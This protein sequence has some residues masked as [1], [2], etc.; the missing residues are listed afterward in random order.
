MRFAFTLPF[1]IASH[2]SVFGTAQAQTLGNDTLYRPGLT[3][4]IRGGLH[5]PA[6]NSPMFDVM[7][8]LLTLEKADFRNPSLGVEFG[9]WVGDRAEIVAGVDAGHMAVSSEFRSRVGTSEPVRQITH[10]SAGPDIF[11]G[12][13]V[14]L[15]PKGKLDPQSGWQQKRWN[16]F[17][18]GGGGQAHYVLQQSG[19][20]VD[21]D[22]DTIVFPATYRSRGGSPYG[23][24]AAGVDVTVFGK[25]GIVVEGRQQWGKAPHTQAGFH[26]NLGKF[27]VSGTRVTAGI[28]VHF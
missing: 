8:E 11:I 21:A 25:V 2:L 7:T 26:D 4:T 27:D 3:I 6:G 23:Y 22:D 10:Y 17:A 18:G 19:N 20:F 28:R 1:L 24:V 5:M 13:K 16:L 9:A 15:F 12:G 14:Y